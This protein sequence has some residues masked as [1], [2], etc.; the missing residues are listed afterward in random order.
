M[1]IPPSP[2]CPL[3]RLSQAVGYRLACRPV[4]C[5]TLGSP[6]GAHKCCTNFKHP[7]SPFGG[8]LL[9]AAAAVRADHAAAL[10]CCIPTPLQ[11][12]QQQQL[13]FLLPNAL[14]N[15][16][17]S[18]MKIAPGTLDYAKFQPQAMLSTGLNSDV[19][20]GD[21]KGLKTKI[22]CKRMSDTL[23]PCTLQQ[24]LIRLV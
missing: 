17:P 13:N 4:R 2:P 23:T 9:P 11:Q 20:M 14:P 12:Q 5:L 16:P 8:H 10:R 24:G 15:A 21:Y 1:N 3:T 18:A 7:V 19:Y 6:G 22:C